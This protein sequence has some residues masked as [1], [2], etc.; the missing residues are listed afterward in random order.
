MQSGEG[1]AAGRISLFGGFQIEKEA[2]GPVWLTGKRGPA[3]LA[4]L[5]RCPGMAAPRERLADLLWGDSDSEHS[6]NSLRQTLSVLRRDLSRAGMDIIHSH[7]ELIGIR[8]N[9]VRVDVEDFEAGL[10]ARSASE[11]ETTLALYTGPFLDGFY[12]GSN[13]FD[14]WAALERE[15]LLSRAL[16]WLEKLARLVDAESGLA[17]A[18]RILSME[19]TREE[20]Y[21]LKM[22]LLVACGQ[23]DKALRTFEACRS[24]LKKEFGVDVSPETRALWQ[25]ISAADG[26]SSQQLVNGVSGVQHVGRPSISVADFVNLTGERADDFFAK[27]LVHDISTALS[28]VANYIILSGFSALEKNGEESKASALP[29]ARY[30][31]SGSIQR[32]GDELRVNVQLVDAAG[33][34]NVWAQK[35]DGHSENALEF[36]DRIAQSVVLAVSLELQLTNWKV[37]DKSPA[38]VPEVRWLVNEALMKYFEMTRDSLLESKKLAEKAL[39]IAPENARAKRTLSIAT[40]MGLAFGALPGRREHVDNAIR[41]AEDSVRAVP[42]DEIAR[43]ILSFAYLCDGRVDEAIVECRHAVSL[44]PSYPSGHGDLGELYGLRGQVSEALRSANEAIRLGT[45]D[46]IDFWRHHALAVALFASGDDRRALEVARRVVRTKPGFV[47]GALYWAAAASATGNN[48]EASRAVHH[49]LS[50]LPHLNLGNVCPGF[51]PRYVK[52]EH[53]ARFLE[54]LSRAGLPRS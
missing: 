30:T 45:H 42:D 38:G 33:G 24:I 12:L 23:R 37:R 47:R 50:Q 10:S 52:D 11:L 39:S 31:L 14:D 27:G 36:Q 53:H 22:E 4:Y 19:P 9:A 15:R 32:S 21:R 1:G 43:C 44:N 29:R 17:V 25:S 48:E 54:M 46:V 26:S 41:L 3:I 51:M 2:G 40:T 5:A 28:E 18:D 6:R 13:A 16:E 7:K 35:F 34:H 49:C 20:S 8:P